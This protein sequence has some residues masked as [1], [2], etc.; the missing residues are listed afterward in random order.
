M[1]SKERNQ[2][3]KPDDR[4]QSGRFIR[5][6]IERGADRRE[7]RSDEIMERLVKRP[8]EPRSSPPPSKKS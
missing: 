7:S 3:P 4:D 1:A 8:P 5:T 2:R 6:A